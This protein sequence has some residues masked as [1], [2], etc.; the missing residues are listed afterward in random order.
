MNAVA[1]SESRAGAN[2]WARI[3]VAVEHRAF[4]DG[5]T[6]VGEGP[7]VIAGIGRPL[8][9]QDTAEPR[10]PIR[11][12]RADVCIIS[13][14]GPETTLWK[15]DAAIARMGPHALEELAHVHDADLV[16]IR[17]TRDVAVHA[18][19]TLLL[20]ESDGGAQD[21]AAAYREALETALAVHLIRRFGVAKATI[22]PAIE[23]ALRFVD[24]N[25]AQPLRLAGLARAAHLSPYHFARRFRE[26]MGVPP[27]EWIVR[28]RIQQAQQLLRAGPDLSLARVASL[29]GFADQSH[30][31]RQFRRR[32]GTTPRRFTEA[33]VPGRCA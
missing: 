19:I 9:V 33:I 8:F 12:A 10:P 1:Q 6:T 28:R 16:T 7:A 30:F 32:T 24:A 13:A 20:V 3:S 26:A 2:A 17:R 31:T 4:T 5:F 22:D 15:G 23:R 14:R 21:G 27:H 11:L 25:L 29:V 18:L